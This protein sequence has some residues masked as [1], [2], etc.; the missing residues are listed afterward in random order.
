MYFPVLVPIGLTG[1]TLSFLVNISDVLM[2]IIIV[3]EAV[4]SEFQPKT[5]EENVFLKLLGLS[6]KYI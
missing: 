1:N 4:I 3:I 2:A 5:S 6:M